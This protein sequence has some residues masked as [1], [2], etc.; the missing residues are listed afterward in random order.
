MMDVARLA[1]LG[2]KAGIKLEGG[3]RQTYRWYMDNLSQAR[4]D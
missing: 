3:L 4:T 2:W 1:R